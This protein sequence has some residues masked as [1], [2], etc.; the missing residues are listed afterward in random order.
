MPLVPARLQMMSAAHRP[1]DDSGWSGGG[2]GRIEL[3]GKASDGRRFKP[4]LTLLR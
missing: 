3:P 4:S 1:P 2:M